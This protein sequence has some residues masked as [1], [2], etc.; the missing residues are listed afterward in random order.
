MSRRPAIVLYVLLM[1]IV[2]VAADVLFFQHH[3]TRRLI[4]N[5]TIVLAFGTFF[6]AFLNRRLP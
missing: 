6:L 5:V 1:V 2:V 3:L 4:A